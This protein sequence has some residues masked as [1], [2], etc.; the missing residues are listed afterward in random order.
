MKR[1]SKIATEPLAGA[2]IAG[3]APAAQNYTAPIGLPHDRRGFTLVGVAPWIQF[4]PTAPDSRDEPSCA[5][6]Y[7]L[8]T[9]WLSARVAA[10]SAVKYRC[11]E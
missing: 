11:T 8:A 5:G 10:R 1:I 6:E 7:P 3:M 9:K 2:F 4:F